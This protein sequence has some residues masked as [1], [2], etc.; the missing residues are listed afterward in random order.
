MAVAR[1]PAQRET[2]TETVLLGVD[3]RMDPIWQHRRA[4]ALVCAEAAIEGNQGN[5]GLG[6]FALLL[7]A[8]GVGYGASRRS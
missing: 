8:I 3:P 4:S 7:A 2:K 5:S 6:W 1:R